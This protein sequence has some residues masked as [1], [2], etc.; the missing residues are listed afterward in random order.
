MCVL[1]SDDEEFDRILSMADFAWTDT[2]TKLKSA[3][4]AAT[5]GRDVVSVKKSMRVDR[6]QVR[7]VLLYMCKIFT[8]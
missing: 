7:T 2:S 8:L 6:E 1:L 4:L 3:M 5:E